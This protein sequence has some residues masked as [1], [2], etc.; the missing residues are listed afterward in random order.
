MTIFTTTI[1]GDHISLEAQL[2]CTFEYLAAERGERERGTGIQ[3]EPD[4]A[5]RC[6]LMQ[7]DLHGVDIFEVLDAECIAMLE[8]IGLCHYE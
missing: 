7:C 8:D 6:I 4:H 2:T 5:A 3:L 1:E